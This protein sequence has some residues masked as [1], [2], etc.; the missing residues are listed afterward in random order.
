MTKRTP[1]ETNEH[2]RQRPFHPAILRPL[3]LTVILH[4]FPYGMQELSS[5]KPAS[6]LGQSYELDDL[7]AFWQLPT[8]STTD[9]RSSCCSPATTKTRFREQSKL[10]S[11]VV[12]SQP[13]CPRL[14]HRPILFESCFQRKSAHHCPSYPTSQLLPALQ[15]RTPR[16][17][18]N[19]QLPWHNS[20]S[21]F[22]TRNSTY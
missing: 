21:W 8:D 20:Q 12:S 16:T 15:A 10:L 6:K 14:H 1:G 3:S 7:T 9:L 19:A 18:F 13:T 4:R 5:A 17:A 2:N 22:E 11:A